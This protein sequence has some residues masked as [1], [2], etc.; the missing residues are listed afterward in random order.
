MA[1]LSKH[2]T[3]MS[4]ALSEDSMNGILRCLTLGNH[5]RASVSDALGEIRE[6]RKITIRVQEDSEHQM[7]CFFLKDVDPQYSYETSL[8]LRHPLA[9]MLEMPAFKSWIDTPGAKHWLTG[10]PGA[11]KTVLASSIIE[12]ALT[13]GSSKIAVAYFFCDYKSE[14]THAV[15]NIL[16]TLAFQLAI[17]R[18]E[19]YAVLAAYYKELHPPHRLSSNPTVSG[20]Q[21]VLSKIIEHYDHCYIIVDG[22]D[23]CTQTVDQ[24]VQTIASWADDEEQ[25]SIALLSRDE[26]NIRFLLEGNYKRI[27]IAAHTRD[28][29]EYVTAQIEERIRKGRFRV[30]DP[31][32]K[33]EIVE[34]L[35]DGACGMSVQILELT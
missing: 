15:V 22:L 23:E 21:N 7:L 26:S 35:K 6:T 4:S 1:E 34:R 8:G 12:A 14:K 24:V 16:G 27:E 19:A 11:E 32:L 9:G 2:K 5:I 31:R 10:I 20:L 17:Q 29:T 25:V 18:K 3:S 28:V 33:G 13:R 30:R